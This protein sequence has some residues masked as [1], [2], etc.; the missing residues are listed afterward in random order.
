MLERNL[1]RLLSSHVHMLS[2]AFIKLKA[3]S[4]KNLVEKTLTHKE[5]NKGS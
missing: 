4:Y 5:T 1:L 3:I 2:M